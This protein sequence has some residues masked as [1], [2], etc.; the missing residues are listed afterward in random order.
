[1]NLLIQE[2]IDKIQVGADAGHSGVYFPESDA[3]GCNWNIALN[4]DRRVLECGPDVSAFLDDLRSRYLV[5]VS[6]AAA[7]PA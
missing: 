1:M 4:T 5:E 6:D 3:T 2:H 7:L